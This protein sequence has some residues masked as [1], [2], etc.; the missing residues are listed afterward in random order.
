MNVPLEG[1]TS[2]FFRTVVGFFSSGM[3]FL[4]TSGT[5]KILFDFKNMSLYN[6]LQP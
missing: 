4:G 3:S 2:I 6:V 1:G 5:L